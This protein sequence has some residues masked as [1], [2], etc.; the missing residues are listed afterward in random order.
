[1]CGFSGEI[2]FNDGR[3]DVNKLKASLSKI[4]HRGPDHSQIEIGDFFGLAHARLSI[5]DLDA[6]SNQ[7]FYSA[8]QRYI[9]AFNGEIYNYKELRKDLESSGIVFRTNSDTEVLLELLITKGVSALNELN[10]FF[11][12]VFIDTQAKK[13]ILA[14]DH[15]GI[16]PLCY[17]I[18]KN[19]L[20]FGSYVNAVKCF[21]DSPS[22]DM[23]AVGQYLQF[24]YIP[25][26][27]TIYSE[28]KKLKPGHFLTFSESSFQE[29]CKWYAPQEQVDPKS[30]LYDL[31]SESVNERLLADV[32]VG[33]FLSGGVD[34]SIIAALAIRHKPDLETFSIGFDD[35]IYDESK[36]AETV[37]R[38]IGSK[39]H[40]IKI[41]DQELISNVTTLV[42][43]IDE[44][45]ADS[46]ALAVFSLCKHTSNTLKVAL[47][48]DGADELFAGYNKHK[49][50]LRSIQPSAKD[51]LAALVGTFVPSGSRSSNL[52]NTFRKLNKWSK[53][54]NL[55][56]L[57]RYLL[58]A[59]FMESEQVKK[60]L[61]KDF[62]TVGLEFDPQNDL[63]DFLELDQ[64]FVL[65]ND[66]LS[67]VDRTSMMNGIEVRVPFLSKKIISKARTYN[68]EELITRDKGKIILQKEFGHMLPEQIFDRKKHGFEVPLSKWFKG[69]M[70]EF[71]DAY[72]N[73]E[74]VKR[75]GLI[76]SNQLHMIKS[77]LD[78]NQTGDAAMHI[79]SISLLHAWLE[80][81]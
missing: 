6:R 81:N 27:R 43:S 7:P 50:L 52:G 73:E 20:A 57:D 10:G 54:V 77:K 79:W 8:D 38:H 26:P 11:A 51:R 19:K 30:S 64:T 63:L 49:A 31:L 15:I 40:M 2:L 47:S 71:V 5:I 24:N 46:S 21:I 75:Y 18:D 69:P 78:N 72:T 48:G 68:T 34:S 16:K 42:D 74:V 44:P 36:Y 17:S 14:R 53:G 66:M 37:A 61:N 12:F 70:N 59:S 28:I 45:F 55:P 39:H 13:G 3:I 56:P 32:S 60:L 1:M 41:S 4:A 65:P 67:K 58:W 35:A 76:N 29:P 22:I 80:N 9:I 62:E 23:D 25:A 33:S